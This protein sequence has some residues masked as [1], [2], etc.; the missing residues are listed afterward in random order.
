M[1]FGD[2]LERC[3]RAA[4]A[5]R[6]AANKRRNRRLQEQGLWPVEAAPELI[7]R[8]NDCR[9]WLP[10]DAFDPDCT[11]ATGRHETCK[12]CIAN[13]RRRLTPAVKAA[14]HAEQGGICAICDQPVGLEEATLAHRV[15]ISLARDMGLDPH[16]LG[17][18]FVAHRRC[19]MRQRTR[20]LAYIRAV[21]ALVRAAM[22][23]WME[24]QIP[25]PYA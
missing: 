11:K 5:E 6:R 10:A 1:R 16:A 4:N 7:Q 17:N 15:A 12:G 2:C 8:C 21:Y 20:S 13:Q 19:N 25:L 18:L 22:H 14:A 24:R 3:V 9:D 23:D